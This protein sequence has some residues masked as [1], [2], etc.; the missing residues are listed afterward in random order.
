MEADLRFRLQTG[1]IVNYDSGCQII[2]V[3]NPVTAETHTLSETNR[4]LRADAR[5]NRARILESARQVFAECGA[6]A[7]IDD[8]ARRAGVGVGTVYRHF[9]T[10]E[11]LMVELVRQKFRLFADRA[12]EALEQGG[13]P[14]AALTD[15]MRRNAETAERD[16][17]TQLAIA[18]AG[19]QIW[20]QARAEQE[21]LLALTD[22]LIARARSAGT[23]R[24]D[25]RA[26]DIGMLMCGVCSAMGLE[27][28]GFNWR[29]HLEL[30]VEMLQPR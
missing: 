20:A 29:R 25:V 22:Q 3:K 30:V 4:P 18:G 21:E 15:V 9:P 13:E 24:P 14:F 11:A 26:S 23:I 12:R 19:E 2:W 10:K 6:E 17:A 16:A 5:R 8:V 27:G 1:T 7:Q 28:L